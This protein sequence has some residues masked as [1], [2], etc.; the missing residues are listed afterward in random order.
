LAN[1]GI[2]QLRLEGG[3]FEESIG[4]LRAALDGDPEYSAAYLALGQAQEGAGDR[5]GALASYE[6]GIEVAARR[7]DMKTANAM[8]QRIA[9]LSEGTAD[10]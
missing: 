2:G 6:R 9:V 3:R 1:F 4:H 10:G 5:R 7:G 8:Q